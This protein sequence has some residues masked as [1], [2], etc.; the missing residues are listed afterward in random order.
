[1]P[2]RGP[3]NGYQAG[4]VSFLQNG[5]ITN[6]TQAEG[7]PAGSVGQFAKDMQGRV[8]V[9]TLYGLARLEGSNWH[10]VGPH[11]RYPEEHPD[12]VFVDS[13][14]K[15]WANTRVGL[16]FLP[17]GQEKLQVADHSFLKMLISKRLPMARYGSLRR[18]A[19]FV[20]SLPEMG[21]TKPM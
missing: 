18:T 3:W 16:V 17:K 12:N 11:G 7:L 13:R 20:P 19:P 5:R 9:A 6:F 8:W 10:I 2:Q 14:G 21:N 4:G 1:M 15:V